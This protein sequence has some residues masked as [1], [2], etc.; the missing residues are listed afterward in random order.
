MTIGEPEA[1]PR[2]LPGLEVPADAKAVKI[3]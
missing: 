2:N 3:G 1:D